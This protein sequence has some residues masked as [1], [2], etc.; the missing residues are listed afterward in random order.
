MKIEKLDVL[1]SEFLYR[2]PKGF[3]DEHFFPTM[4]KFK[5]E[6]LE[7]F[8]KE[9]LK[10]ENFSNPNLIVDGFFKTIQKSVMVSLFDKLKLKDALSS[11]NSY[12]KDM[13][14]IE[15][16]ELLYGDKKVGFEGLVEFLNEYKL[17][18][19][20][21]ISVVPYSINRQTEYVI[22]P[23]T[24]KN[25]IK[26]FD[27]KNLDYKPK[28]SFEFYQNYTKVLDEMKSKLDKSLTFDNAAYTGFFKIAIELCED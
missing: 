4:K 13:L 19:W 15:I 2:F 3:E 9:A 7:E 1:E 24:T 21:L 18:K 27:L 16:Y 26:Y 17:A 8:A 10:K 25:I 6:K 14:S 20:T 28:P 11:L 5:P 23:T 12:E 22:K